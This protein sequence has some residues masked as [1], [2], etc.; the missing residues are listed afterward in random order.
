VGNGKA[1]AKPAAPAE[2]NIA[3][4]RMHSASE[5]MLRQALHA[6]A[7]DEQ[8]A[9][10]E[11]AV[12]MAVMALYAEDGEWYAA[13]ISSLGDDFVEVYFDKYDEYATVGY[14]S[15]A[16]AAE[17]DAPS[18]GAAGRKNS[19]RPTSKAAFVPPVPASNPHKVQREALPAFSHRAEL[20]SAIRNHQVVVVEGST[21]CGKTTQ[22]PQYVLE[23]A[24][25]AG[26]P[27]FIV[28]TQPRRIS[29]MSVAERVAAERGER[30]GG[31]VGYSIRLESKS[32]SDTCLL[33]CTSG[34]LTRRL[35]EDRDLDGA[36]HVFVDEVHERSMESDFLLMVLRDLLERRPGLRL[37]LMSATLDARLFADYF[38][39]GG[40][41]TVPT[42]SMPGRAF[43]VAALFLEDAMELVG[44]VVRPGTDW[45]R[46]GGGKGGKGG[47]GGRGGGGRGAPPPVAMRPG[48][49]AC[50]TC[51]TVAFAS[52]LACFKCNTPKPP[53]GVGMGAVVGRGG[54]LPNGGM[55]GRG[56]ARGPMAGGRGGR[57]GRG[58]GGNA[59]EEDH[60]D[61]RPDADLSLEELAQRYPAS[62]DPVHRALSSVDFEVINVDLVVQLV[63]WLSACDGPESITEWAH[64]REEWA[65]RRLLQALMLQPQGRNGATAPSDRPP[66]PP[67]NPLVAGRYGGPPNGPPGGPPAR[68]H[69]AARQRADGEAA[70]AILVFLPGFK[71][72]QSVHEALLMT[73][74]FSCEPHRSWLLPLHSM[75]PPEDQRKVFDRPPPGVRKVRLL[76]IPS[77][78]PFPPPVA[79]THPP[80]PLSAWV[81]L[82]TSPRPA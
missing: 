48:D 41:V 9:A 18:A 39:Q 42:V 29:A 37:I 8:S 2:S 40:K 79:P 27:C 36:T 20:L 25:A 28:C 46:R 1:A 4:V 66:P 81:V 14:D 70:D 82:H 62:G 32:S 26:E 65:Q 7:L 52:K 56:G 53:P 75:L 72:I 19:R 6:H 5:S 67:P 63:S 34:I 78:H 51:G 80:F 13:T 74:R 45:A 59:V 47:G 3:S 64:A 54:G 11:L 24:A 68:A 60:T 73:P 38:S 33:F 35:E 17:E 76:P 16:L 61:S 50:P 31:A 12:G 44:H 43:P 10:D 58:G 77:P 49:W 57:G 55:G 71:E 21:G 69:P 15:I 23:E 22:V 30:L